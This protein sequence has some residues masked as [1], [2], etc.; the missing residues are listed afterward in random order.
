MKKIILMAAM[1][2]LSGCGADV[3]V[4]KDNA[5]IT[6]DS[7]VI[8]KCKLAALKVAPANIVTKDNSMAVLGYMLSQPNSS[9]NTSCYGFG[10]SLNCTTSHSNYRTPMPPATII[11]DTNAGLRDELFKVCM[12]YE[13]FKVKQ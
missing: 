3:Y 4:K 11:V 9:S 10:Y 5:N 8:S 13:G 1:I 2:A 12:D 6:A 7:G